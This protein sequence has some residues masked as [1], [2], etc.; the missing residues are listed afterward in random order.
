MT[1]ICEHHIYMHGNGVLLFLE[2]D[3]LLHPLLDRKTT[4]ESWWKAW[5]QWG[6]LWVLL[7]F[8]RGMSTYVS[9]LTIYLFMPFF[10]LPLHQSNN[11]SRVR[12][13]E[14]IKDILISQL[15]WY[16]SD[17]Q[18]CNTCEEVREAYRKKGWALTNVESI[19]QVLKNYFLLFYLIV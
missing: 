3:Y 13:I 18:C 17:D 1:E 15:Q 11:F 9:S 19:D 6:L 14:N 12:F 7:W 10:P 5:P 16:Q 8:G 4:A 2:L